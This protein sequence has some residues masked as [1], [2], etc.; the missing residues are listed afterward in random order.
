MVQSP[1]K[2]PGYDPAKDTMINKRHPPRETPEGRRW[3]R[4]GMT[5]YQRSMYKIE[6][7][8]YTILV[9]GSRAVVLDDCAVKWNPGDIVIDVG[10]WHQWSSRTPEGGDVP[11]DMISAKFV[12]GPV[13][14]AQS[15]DK[16]LSGPSA[17]ALPPGVKPTR[18]IVI[19]GREPYKLPHVSDAPTSDIRID[20][21]R[22]GYCSQ[23]RWGTD[24]TPCNI[25]PETPHLPH[26]IAPPP[27]G[28]VVNVINIAPDANRKGKVGEEQVRAFFLRMG[29]PNAPMRRTL[30]G[31]RCAR[32]ISSSCRKAKLCWCSTRRKS[33]ARKAT[34]SRE[35]AR[36]MRGAIAQT[37]LRC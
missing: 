30:T 14:L 2:Q 13:G 32:W 25:V 9:N 17:T 35:A 23:R 22:P 28:S 1:G 16:L 37:S 26:T 31:K 27:A 10:A 36:G 24:G 18:R 15:N 8:D 12:D 21:A 4:G 29:S 3:D 34:S 6:I 19:T 20:P 5:K 7:V 11:F 33:C